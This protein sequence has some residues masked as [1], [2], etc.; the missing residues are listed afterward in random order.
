[1]KLA[2]E[3]LVLAILGIAFLSSCAPTHAS[4]PLFSERSAA[5]SVTRPVDVS[6]VA[7]APCTSLLTD[8]EL[9]GMGF[10]RAG[11][12]RE[13]LGVMEC[14]WTSDDGQGMSVA[15]DENRNLLADAYRT[16][17]SGI[18]EPM[19]VIGYPAVREKTGNGNLNSC[20][21]TT[22]L[23]PRQALTTDWFGRG[24]PVPGN[25]ACTFAEQVTVAVVRKLPPA[26]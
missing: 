8:R 21:I 15:V 26:L 18:F 12:Q 20:V 17:R 5:P 25:D 1:M 22:G 19:V 14:S 4:S 23:G 24:V 13:Y 9:H 7:S 11:R 16:Y 2:S 10:Q 3:R 6:Q